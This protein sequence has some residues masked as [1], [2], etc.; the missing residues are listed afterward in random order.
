MLPPQTTWIGEN[1][2]VTEACWKEI[3]KI[4]KK[5]DQTDTGLSKG[6]LQSVISTIFKNS[7]SH[8]QNILVWSSLNQ[9]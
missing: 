3:E 2:T 4:F 5:Y 6:D 1:K 7:S 8:E 9:S